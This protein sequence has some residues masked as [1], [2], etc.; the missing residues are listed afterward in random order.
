M[1]YS[2]TTELKNLTGTVLTDQILSDIIAQ[3][4]RTIDAKLRKAGIT[5]ANS[6]DLKMV[7]LEYAIA[8]LFTRYRLDGTKPSSLSLGDLSMSDTIDA[9][10]ARHLDNGDKLLNDIIKGKRSYRQIVRVVNKC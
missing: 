3:A 1:A 7:S 8:G 2:T 10:I 5:S 6:D 4:D 9:A